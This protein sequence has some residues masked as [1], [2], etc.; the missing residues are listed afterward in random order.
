MKKHI[1]DLMIVTDEH[2]LLKEKKQTNQQYE[3][4]KQ[5]A[6]KRL[7]KVLDSIKPSQRANA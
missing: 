5:G 7:A 2:N 1:L 6:F 4:I 3:Q